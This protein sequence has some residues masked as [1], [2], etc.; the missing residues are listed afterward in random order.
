MMPTFADA[1]HEMK[2]IDWLLLYN[3]IVTRLPSDQAATI[4]AAY[5]D[6]Q[7]RGKYLGE[8]GAAEAI[9]RACIAAAGHRI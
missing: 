4:H 5:L 2:P 7:R 3:Q 6:L 9:V 8:N 1:V